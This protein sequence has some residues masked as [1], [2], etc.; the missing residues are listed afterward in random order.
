MTDNLKRLEE[1]SKIRKKLEEI[2]M[3]INTTHIISE[4]YSNMNT[5]SNSH[6]K[7]EIYR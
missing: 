3:L 1:E 5:K 2:E 6:D 4:R 7:V